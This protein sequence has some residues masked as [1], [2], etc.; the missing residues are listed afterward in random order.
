ML[1]GELPVVCLHQHCRPRHAGARAD[2]LENQGA[3]PGIVP[4][5]RRA[6]EQAASR[7]WASWRPG[8][9]RVA[10]LFDDASLS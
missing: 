8:G 2:G 10:D 7:C 6:A 4:D 9:R 1:I 3:H 5:D